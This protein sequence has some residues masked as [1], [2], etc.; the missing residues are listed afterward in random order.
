MHFYATPGRKPSEVVGRAFA[1]GS[2]GEYMET[3]IFRPG[4]SAF[5]GTSKY[6]MPLIRA[7]R[8]N[9]YDYFYI[10]NG[11]LK[12]SIHRNGDYSGYYRVTKNAEQHDG[13]GQHDYSRF[14]SLGITLDPWETRGENILVVCQSKTY[15]EVRYGKL[16]NWLTNILA[17]IARFTDRPII[18]RPKPTAHTKRRDIQQDLDKAWCVVTYTSNVAV[19]AVI[20][21][22]PVFTTG[23]CVAKKMSG[24]LSDIENPFF[25]DRDQW[26][27]NLSANQW[28]IEE[29]RD[30][31]CWRDLEKL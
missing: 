8:E 28:T 5:Y 13:S 12:P 1:M 6:T 11:Y 29:I 24:T 20:Q 21:G 19:E 30:G 22:I 25:P 27:A 18:V 26:A 2:G 7:C 16:G 4:S 15:F 14:K 9:D 3:C 31:T 23:E 10:D 17:E